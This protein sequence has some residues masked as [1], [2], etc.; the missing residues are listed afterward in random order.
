M[1]LYKLENG[2]LRQRGVVMQTALD[3]V[4]RDKAV[5]PSPKPTYDADELLSWRVMEEYC[6]RAIAL[7]RGRVSAAEHAGN[8]H[9]ASHYPSSS[10][11]TSSC[12]QVHSSWI[13]FGPLAGARILR[14]ALC[15]GKQMVGA[16]CRVSFGELRSVTIYNPAIRRG[17]IVRGLTYLSRRSNFIPVR[18]GFCR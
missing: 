11:S 5:S 14:P 1:L 6:Y 15:S 12:F 2:A 4:Q 18:S 13:E 9:T 17:C 10:I 16:E 3:F 8:A 7:F